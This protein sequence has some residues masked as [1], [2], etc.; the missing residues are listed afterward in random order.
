MRDVGRIHQEKVQG[1]TVDL[2]VQVVFTT[3]RPPP[4]TPQRHT[5]PDGHFH[6]RHQCPH[7]PRLASALYHQSSKNMTA[8]VVICV[9]NL[10]SEALLLLLLLVGCV[11]PTTTDC[12]LLLTDWPKIK[13]SARVPHDVSS[14]VTSIIGRCQST[15]GLLVGT[16]YVITTQTKIDEESFWWKFE[17]SQHASS[18]NSRTRTENIQA[19]RVILTFHSSSSNNSINSNSNHGRRI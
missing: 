6:I 4:P 7:V 18:H 19:G 11:S 13:P 2:M 15:D 1:I 3:A 17:K 8:G 10:L 14:R 12:V 9:V 16:K 5:T